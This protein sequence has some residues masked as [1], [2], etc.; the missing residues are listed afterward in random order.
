MTNNTN[1]NAT[2]NANQNTSKKSN[3]KNFKRNVV[4]AAGVATVLSLALATPSFAHP[5]VKGSVAK[6][7]KAAASAPR[8]AA[9]MATVSA[10]ITGVPTTVTDAHAAEHGARFVVYPLAADATSAPATQPTTG[11]HPIGIR[12]GTL[13]NGVLTGNLGLKGGAAGTTTKLAIYPTSGGSAIFATVTVDAAGVATAVTSGA[14]TATFDATLKEP[15]LGEGKSPK[16]DRSSRH[17]QGPKGDRGSEN[18]GAGDR[19][20]GAMD[21]RG[22]GDRGSENRGAGDRAPRAGVAATANVPADGKTYSIRITE[23]FEDGVAVTTPEA[24]TGPALTGSG[25]LAIKLPLGKGDTYKVELVAADGTVI[26]T[27]TV[28][29]AA[30]GTVATP[31]TLG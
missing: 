27:T 15:A 22:A 1:P 9:A 12:G 4:A 5:S 21:D 13:T 8:V 14:L 20:P 28:V 23:T 31:I 2:Q 11:G 17:G 10:T 19:A 24:K 3:N 25:A 26:G 6:A 18:R 16:G 30:D 29:V 7:S